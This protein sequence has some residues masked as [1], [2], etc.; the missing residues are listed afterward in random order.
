MLLNGLETVG[1]VESD[2]VT[3][4]NFGQFEDAT[5][6]SIDGAQ[7]FTLRFKALKSGKLSEMLGV[8]GAITRAEAY[9]LTNHQVT[10][11]NGCSIPF[12]RQDPDFSRDWFRTVPEPA[13][14]VCEQDKH[15]LLPTG[16]S[17][18]NAVNF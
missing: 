1:V 15:R 6:V 2:H 17:G 13:E 4:S 7:E 5:T 16:S 3:A 18:S 8:S 14:P 9:P 11:P 12:Q 10:S